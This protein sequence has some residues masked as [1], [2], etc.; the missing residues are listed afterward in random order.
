MKLI[1]AI[2]MLFAFSA[3][4]NIGIPTPVKKPGTVAGP[5]TGKFAADQKLVRDLMDSLNWD[6]NTQYEETGLLM[7]DLI[8]SLI[9]KNAEAKA[10]VKEVVAYMNSDEF[11]NQDQNLKNKD[12][13][14]AKIYVKMSIAEFV[15]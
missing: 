8:L 4:A 3:Q 7:K 5:S 13:F 1:I 14:E 15:L 10:W 9:K 6:Q 12:I 11:Q 2:T